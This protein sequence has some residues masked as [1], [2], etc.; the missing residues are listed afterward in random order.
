MTTIIDRANRVVSL[1]EFEKNVYPIELSN[2]NVICPFENQYILRMC[3]STDG[4]NFLI[5]NEMNWLKPLF[6]EALTHQKNVINVEKNF[7]Y[8]TVRHGVVKSVTDD[9]WHVD[10][11]STKISHV[12]EQNYIW[13]NS[14]PTEYTNVS[15]K[16]PDDFDPLKHNVNHFLEQNITDEIKQCKENVLYCMDPYIIHRRPTVSTGTVRTFVR[17]SFVPIMIDDIN[18]TQNPKLLQNYKND[19]IKY[20]NNLKKYETNQ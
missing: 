7:C 6:I 20:R 8:I 9:E 19:G 16:F 15:V 13:T 5:P 14:I 17:I 12:P 1:A 3:V 2:I 10:G 18:N 4:I 11:F